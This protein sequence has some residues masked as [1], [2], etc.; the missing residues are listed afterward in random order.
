[1]ST[2]TGRNEPCPCGSGKKYKYCHG[3]GGAANA[4]NV[5]DPTAAVPRALAWL[6]LRHGKAMSALFEQL[7]FEDLWPDDGPEPDDVDQDVWSRL[8][9]NL[10]EWILAEGD[11]EVGSEWRIVNELVCSDRGPTL[12]ALQRDCIAQLATQPLALYT[13]TDVRAGEGITLV[14][15]LQPGSAPRVVD[16][17]GAAIAESGDLIGCRVIEVGGARRLSGA[18]YPFTAH[19]APFALYAVAEAADPDMDSEE[20]RYHTG[21]A[22]IAEWIDQ[23]LLPPPVLPMVDSWTGEPLMSIVDHYRILDEDRLIEALDA[24]EGLTGHEGDLWTLDE[25][26]GD[27]IRIRL[28]ISVGA[29]DGFLEVFYRTQRLADEGRLWFESLAGAHVKHRSREVKDPTAGV[30]RYIEAAG[31]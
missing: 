29:K 5:D 12:G 18:I 24:S 31:A 26:D 27:T 14:D 7:L 4:G 10:N 13:V 15:A 11:I 8:V 16:V 9:F 3:E 30:R 2:R 19:H 28:E 17:P 23:M 22:V 21:M 25:P 1:M 20:Q 6:S